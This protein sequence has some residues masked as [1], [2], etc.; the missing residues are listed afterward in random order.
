MTEVVLYIDEEEISVSN[1][2]LTTAADGQNYRR[3][4]SG[5]LAIAPL[6]ILYTVCREWPLP[7]LH[8]NCQGM[9]DSSSHKPWSGKRCASSRFATQ[10]VA[11]SIV[12][13]RQVTTG[14]SS[15]VR[16]GERVTS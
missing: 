1:C 6:P 15:L 7:K 8:G 11:N 3:A 4:R 9:L 14:K 2:W 5:M 10:R 13:T 16:A 12:V